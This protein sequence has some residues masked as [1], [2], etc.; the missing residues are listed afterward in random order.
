MLL[1]RSSACIGPRCGSSTLRTR[2]RPWM[3]VAYGRSD[4]LR[5]LSQTCSHPR[6]LTDMTLTGGLSRQQ[7]LQRF[8]SVYRD[9]LRVSS[10]QQKR[11]LLWSRLIT[12]ECVPR[13][14]CEY[15][16]PPNLR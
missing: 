13:P 12:S 5:G 1:A 14:G 8:V 4:R 15:P 3:S 9:V 7:E 10:H 6:E 16:N 11:T 2:S